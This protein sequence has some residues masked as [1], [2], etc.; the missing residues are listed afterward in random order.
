M[1]TAFIVLYYR[2][3]LDIDLLVYFSP[4]VMVV[5]SIGEQSLTFIKKECFI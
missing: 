2:S 1:L 4:Y 5:S 3:K